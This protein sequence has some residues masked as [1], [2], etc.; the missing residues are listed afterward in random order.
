MSLVGLSYANAPIHSFAWLV[1]PDVDT[2]HVE[3]DATVPVWSK[4][5]ELTKPLISAMWQCVSP[6]PE[7]LQVTVLDPAFAEA[8]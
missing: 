2:E 3:E 1:A 8:T 7:W 4:G 5:D 6:L